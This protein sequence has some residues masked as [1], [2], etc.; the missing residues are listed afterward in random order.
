MQKV[1]WSLVD[2]S[3][4]LSQISFLQDTPELLGFLRNTSAS[5]R[6][7]KRSTSDGYSGKTLVSL[8]HMNIP[9]RNQMFIRN[10]QV[11]IL[12]LLFSALRLFFT[13]QNCTNISCLKI[14]CIVGRLDRGQSAVVKIRSRLW[15]HTF[16]QVSVLIIRF[17]WDALLLKTA[18]N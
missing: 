17:I 15:A 16:L 5:S 9:S 8:T 3:R 14:L 12:S 18:V 4:F 2:N 13:P 6:R 11:F 7:H 1:K 10:S